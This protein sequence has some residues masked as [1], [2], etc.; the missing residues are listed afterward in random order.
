MSKKKNVFRV[1]FSEN[2]GLFTLNEKSGAWE[3]NCSTGEKMVVWLDPNIKDRCV[4]LKFILQGA[5]GKEI[6]K[7]KNDIKVTNAIMFPPVIPEPLCF[8]PVRWHSYWQLSFGPWVSLYPPELVVYFPVMIAFNENS[9]G[10]N[11]LFI[12]ERPELLLH[13]KIRVTPRILSIIEQ[14]KE[15]HNEFLEQDEDMEQKSIE[16]IQ[17]TNKEWDEWE[18]QQAEDWERRQTEKR[19]NQQKEEQDKKEESGE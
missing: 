13:Q 17:Q 18:R 10:I 2:D 7:E 19:K 11:R 1:R 5:D 16:C 15:R 6:S 9:F 3:Y 8:H 4:Y 12:P 14:G